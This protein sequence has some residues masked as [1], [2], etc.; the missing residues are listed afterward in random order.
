MCQKRQFDIIQLAC[1]E[2]ITLF[3]TSLR[4][5]EFGLYA[6][7]F[8]SD[9]PECKSAIVACEEGLFYLRI[10]IKHRSSHTTA[11]P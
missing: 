7:T 5:V 10:E 6:Q 9:V 3:P 1:I 11:E 2:A 8:L 4:V